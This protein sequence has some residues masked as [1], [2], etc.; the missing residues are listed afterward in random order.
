MAA[1]PLGFNDRWP[2]KRALAMHR[3][4][5]SSVL[6]PPEMQERTEEF[7]KISEEE[8]DGLVMLLRVGNRSF[9]KRVFHH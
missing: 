7:K 6:F 9:I 3:P 5:N 4:T 1:Y 2:C 8:E